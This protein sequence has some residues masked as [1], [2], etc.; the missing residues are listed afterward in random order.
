MTRE[1]PFVDYLESLREN[2]GALAGLR[3]GLGRAPGEAREMYPYVVPWVALDAPRDRE[4]A[5]YLI[6]ALYAFHPMPGG[7][8]NM[9]AHFTRTFEPGGDRTAV[10]RRFTGLLTA[11]HD[12][13]P[14]HLRQ[15]VGV[16]KSKDVPVDWRRLLAD[17]LAW[18][19]P[20]G[21]VQK[22]W[23]RAFWGRAADHTPDA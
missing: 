13:L 17:L 4:A 10:E 6:A 5:Y 2:R 8:G 11:H 18:S 21:Y 22:Q 16:L 23:A 12:D 7:S 19:H 9:G 14:F 1:Q 15:A 3:R 20:D